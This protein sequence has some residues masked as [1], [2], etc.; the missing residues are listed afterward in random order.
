MARRQLTRCQNVSFQ[1][2]LMTRSTSL[3]PRRNSANSSFTRDTST[4]LLNVL[5]YYVG[6][7]Q[8]WGEMSRRVNIWEKMVYIASMLQLY[9]ISCMS[10]F[11]PHLPRA[12]C[13]SR[14]CCFAAVTLGTLFSSD[15]CD[16]V[17]NVASYMIHLSVSLSTEHVLTCWLCVII[18]LCDWQMI[19]V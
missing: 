15:H 8:E 16:I 1:S 9:H 3:V 6:Y 5:L 12:R 11:C 17:G 19:F 14:I 18:D 4:G 7:N 10:C 13:C 2:Y